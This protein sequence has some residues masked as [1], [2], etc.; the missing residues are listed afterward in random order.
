MITSWIKE[1]YIEILGV[2]TSL[3]YLYFSVR[4]YILLWPFGIISS[5]F[6]IYIFF[7][8]RFYADMS[9]QGYYLVVSVY[10]WFHWVRGSRKSAHDRLPVTR[11][12]LKTGLILLPIFIFL[13]LSMVKILD[14][15][16]DSDIPWGDAFMTAGSIIATWMLARKILE[17]WLIWI[18]VD[19]VS[20][21][22]YLYKEMYPTG[23]L[24]FVFT[25]IAILGFFAWK[26]EMS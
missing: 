11:I 19:A 9:L 12:S 22:F 20:V 16:T 8:N 4:Q 24:Y 1:N 14:H 26:R 18:I 25:I 6:F 17:H 3:I 21:G 13:W 5:S 15:Y 23:L 2:I 7:V 10:G